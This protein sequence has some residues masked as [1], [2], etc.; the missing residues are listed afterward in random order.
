MLPS[1]PKAPRLRGFPRGLGKGHDAAVV[2][3]WLNEELQ[4][5]DVASADT[6]ICLSF[7][8]FFSLL[9]FLHFHSLSL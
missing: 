8:S 5:I 3:A 7:C 6:R 1:I 9:T 4:Q 2:G